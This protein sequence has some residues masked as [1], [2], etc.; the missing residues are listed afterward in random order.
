MVNN[1]NPWEDEGSYN[2]SNKTERSPKVRNI[3]DFKRGNSNNIF[4]EF[5]WKIKWVIFAL[6]IIWL[7][8]G[9]YQIEPNEQGVVLQFG[10]YKNTTEAGLNY[11]LPYP[12][13]RVMK[14]NQTQERSFTLG[15][16][17]N[18]YSTYNSRSR[19]SSSNSGAYDNFTESHM[20]TGDESIVDINLTIVWK[21]KDSKDYLFS[22]REP[23]QTVYVAAQSVLREIV[24]QSQM[25][26]II[27][28]DRGKVEEDTKRELQAVLDEFKSGIIITRVQ[29]QK[30]DPPSQVVDAFNE[31]QRARND[32]EK[33]QEQAL[34]YYNKVVPKAEGEAIQLL[35]SAKAY[36][37]KVINEAIGETQRFQSIHNAYK[38]GREVTSSRMYIETIE[39][40]L[41]NSNTTIIDPS[42]KG[43]N[44]LPVLP[45]NK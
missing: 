44:V 37:E 39:E 16:S 5:Q 26:E 19:Y 32:K 15:L 31:V 27:T 6:F 10:A 38:Q 43:Q 4:F 45:L 11:H 21:I 14:V 35:N 1:K 28:G 23:D 36:K 30:A 7:L 3:S 40:V 12:I 2:K 8:S 33:Y 42:A 41:N 34:A 17:N 18:S 9:F 24:G 25:M 20:L 22:L 13:E 29:L